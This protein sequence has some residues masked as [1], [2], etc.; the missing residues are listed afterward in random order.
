MIEI[1]AVIFYIIAIIINVII[2]YKL[3]DAFGHSLGFMMLLI[4]I[5]L[6]AWLI[7]GFSDDEQPIYKDLVK[8][9]I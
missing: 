4:F 1:V 8:T 5:P 7:L 3:S 6:L 9:I 2:N